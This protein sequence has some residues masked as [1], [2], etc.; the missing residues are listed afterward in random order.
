MRSPPKEVSPSRCLHGQLQEIHLE[1]LN[2]RSP[3]PA[4]PF[5]L[6]KPNHQ[7]QSQTSPPNWDFTAAMK[8]AKYIEIDGRTG[9]GGGQIVRIACALAAVTTQPIRI[10]N[11]RA[12]REGPRGGGLSHPSALS[13]KEN[14]PANPPHQVSNPSTSP[15]SP[16]SSPSRTPKSRASPSAPRPS[17]SARAASHQ[18]SSPGASPS[19][20]TPPRPAPSSSSKPSCPS[21]S[22]PATS[23]APTRPSS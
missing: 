19:Q 8:E 21:S 12:N 2:T 3:N 1:P 23:A 18:T 15:P 6:S 22:S 14:P 17:S 13:P 20:P 9:E 10:T 5:T 11:I 7:G 4:L 16:G